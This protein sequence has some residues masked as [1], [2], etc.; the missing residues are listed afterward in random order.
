MGQDVTSQKMVIVVKF[1]CNKRYYK[2]KS[3]KFNH[4]IPPIF[5]FDEHNY[6]LELNVDLYMLFLRVECVYGEVHLM[7]K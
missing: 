7:E 1:N 3:A 4:S 5:Y 6:C 2:Q